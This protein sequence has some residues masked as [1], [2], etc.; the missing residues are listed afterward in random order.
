MWVRVMRGGG[1][2][3]QMVMIDVYYRINYQGDYGTANALGVVW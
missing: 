1:E 2:P 3:P